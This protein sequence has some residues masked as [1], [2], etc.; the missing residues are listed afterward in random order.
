[1]PLYDILY[2]SVVGYL[3]SLHFLTILNNPAMNIYVEVQVV[4]WTYF[5]FLLDVYLGIELLCHTYSH[6]L[7]FFFF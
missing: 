4:M 7:L 6:P 1:M 5:L 3:G 2:S